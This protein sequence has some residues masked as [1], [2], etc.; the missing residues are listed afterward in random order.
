VTTIYLAA[1]LFTLAEQEFNVRV[2]DELV[3]RDSRL[4]AVVP[5][6]RSS[7]LLALPNGVELVFRD[8]IEMIDACDV[9]VAI[10]EGPG[11]DSGTWSRSVTRTR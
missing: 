3:A 5:Q 4:T 1:P 7:A 8:C 9:V 2:R 10:V 11:A 6:E